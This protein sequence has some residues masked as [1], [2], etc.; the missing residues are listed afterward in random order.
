L[1]RGEAARK[2]RAANTA[3]GFVND[4]A[5]FAKH[6]ALRRVEVETPNGPVSLAAPPVIRS[7]GPP[8][9]GPVPA[10]GEHSAAIRA[11]FG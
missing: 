9:L 10:L 5:D 11:E 6:P 8:A 1:D 4:V 3:F 2:L 7:D